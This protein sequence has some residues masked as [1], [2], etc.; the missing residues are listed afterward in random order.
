MLWA[1]DW[2]SG[3][4]EKEV[5]GILWVVTGNNVKWIVVEQL[6]RKLD[7]EERQIWSAELDDVD[8]RNASCV[9]EGSVQERWDACPDG[10]SG[11]WIEMIWRPDGVGIELHVVQVEGHDAVVLVVVKDCVVVRDV[12]GVVVSMGY[13]MKQRSMR[14]VWLWTRSGRHLWVAWCGD[15]RWR[16][17]QWW[18][19]WNWWRRR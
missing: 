5:M 14:V 12:E 11:I 10:T 19:S 9:V 18:W 8:E 6:K 2:T 4:V 17:V 15:W 13:G 1:V 16:R 7:V 3:H